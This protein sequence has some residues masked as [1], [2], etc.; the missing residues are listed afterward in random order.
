[1]AVHALLIVFLTLKVGNCVLVD[2]QIGDCAVEA[3]ALKLERGLSGHVLAGVIRFPVWAS[4]VSSLLSGCTH[5]VTPILRDFTITDLWA[6]IP[7]RKAVMLWE[8]VSLLH[9]DEKSVPAYVCPRP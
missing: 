1:M 5:F 6:T 7:L 3:D 9:S 8:T 4:K 2:G